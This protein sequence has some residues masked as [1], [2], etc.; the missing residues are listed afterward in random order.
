MHVPH[1]APC[2]L[3][4][5]TVGARGAAQAEGKLAKSQLSE[6]RKAAGLERRMSYI[7]RSVE[8]AAQEQDLIKS[9]QL[10]KAARKGLHLGLG[11]PSSSHAGSVQNSQR[12]PF[13]SVQNSHRSAGF[14]SVQ[15]SHR[16]QSQM[17]SRM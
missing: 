5:H 11:S 10:K 16:S 7:S 12:S 9:H 8:K 3:S 13:G 1:R 2:T 4:P 15:N 6:Q 17:S 14:G